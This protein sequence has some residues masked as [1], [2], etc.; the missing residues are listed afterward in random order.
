MTT[1]G[2]ALEGAYELV[3]KRSEGLYDITQSAKQLK[4]YLG[5]AL[6]VSG[7]KRFVDLCDRSQHDSAMMTKHA[8]EQLLSIV[9]VPVEFWQSLIRDAA[10]G[11]AVA[12]DTARNMFAIAV[13]RFAKEDDDESQK[14]VR[15]IVFRA[16]NRSVRSVFLA[17]KE[18]P[19][20]LA[21]VKELERTLSKVPCRV[22]ACEV[23][24]S[25]TWFK[26]T[27]DGIS[28]DDPIDGTGG[29][30]AGFFVQNSETG[31]YSFSFKPFIFRES[32][33]NDL[34]VHTENT[35]TAPETFA[36][37][38]VRAFI[39]K[40]VS[41]T[42]ATAR[43]HCSRF[44]ETDQ[45]RLRYPYSVIEAV[46]LRLGFGPKFANLVKLSFDKQQ[47]KTVF[48]VINAITDAAKSYDGERAPYRAAYESGAGV[49]L[50]Y[51]P[52]TWA[53]LDVLPKKSKA[54]V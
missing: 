53:S 50:T 47:R 17:G 8:I 9:G 7:S 31:M 37:E 4:V 18:P 14:K 51:S 27:F 11:N 48:G 32:C 23:H 33:T 28:F 30:K 6:Y 10:A 5:D 54:S 19:K 44:S 40:C 26:V 34:V 16:R 41:T 25:V 43:A 3:K 52:N 12:M 39:K 36:P 22:R 45:V 13:E 2:S 29:L 15:D 42:F 46:C 1:T 35:A 38:A 20:D 49:L 21:I 24:E